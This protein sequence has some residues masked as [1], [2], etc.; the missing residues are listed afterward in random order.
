MQLRFDAGGARD[1]RDFRPRARLLAVFDQPTWHGAEGGG[2]ALPAGQPAADRS[3]A[4]V[5]AA[6]RTLAPQQ[7]NGV[8]RQH[9]DEQ[10]GADALRLAVPHRAQA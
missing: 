10:V 1:L 4:A 6:G 2:G 7:M 3:P 9:R 8:K 5:E